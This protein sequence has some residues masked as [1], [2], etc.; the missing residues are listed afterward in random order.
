[1]RYKSLAASFALAMCGSLVVA[2]CGGSESPSRDGGYTPGAIEESVQVWHDSDGFYTCPP[3]TKI[4]ASAPSV[5][6]ADA[7]DRVRLEGDAIDDAVSADPPAPGSDNPVVKIV[8]EVDDTG[9]TIQVT[10]ATPE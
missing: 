4:G 1:M 2:G 8:G 9:Y 6:T 10:S 7:S 5:C 3:N